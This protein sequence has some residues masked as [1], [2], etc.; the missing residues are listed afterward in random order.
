MGRE[1]VADFLSKI[2]SGPAFE[3]AL[4]DLCIA[5]G[6]GK[7]PSGGGGVQQDPVNAKWR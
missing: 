2:V 6:E 5:A 3:K 4:Q 1:L 7:V